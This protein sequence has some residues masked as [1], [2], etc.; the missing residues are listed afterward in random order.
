MSLSD[1]YT[2][3]YTPLENSGVGN[4][5]SLGSEVGLLVGQESPQLCIIYSLSYHSMRYLEASNRFLGNNNMKSSIAK[6]NQLEDR[7]YRLE[8]NE[9]TL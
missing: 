1:L 3:L 6:E 8:H 5:G 9:Q 4:C 7:G 2:P